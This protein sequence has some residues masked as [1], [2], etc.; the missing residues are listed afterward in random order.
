M[1]HIV[2]ILGLFLVLSLLWNIKQSKE[3]INARQKIYDLLDSVDTVSDKIPES[4]DAQSYA[5]QLSNEL[6]NYFVVDEIN[7]KVSIT[8]L[9][10]PI[11]KK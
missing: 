2:I 9:K 1:N 10:K 6:K 3:L 4:M 11:S 5:L 8:V 7:N